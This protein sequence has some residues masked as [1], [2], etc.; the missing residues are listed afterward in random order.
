MKLD[1]KG[2]FLTLYDLFGQTSYYKKI[3][4]F[5]IYTKFWRS[6]FKQKR[7]RRERLFLNTKMTV[8]DLQ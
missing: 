6:N 1:I 3:C 8:S 7:Y 5:I 2:L 4:V